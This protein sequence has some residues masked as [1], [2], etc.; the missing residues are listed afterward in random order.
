MRVVVAYATFVVTEYAVW[1]AML[2]FAFGQ[3]GATTA[4]V[5]ALAQLVPAAVAAPVAAAIAD[6]RS[7]V[8]LLVAGYLLQALGTAAAAV[9]IVVGAPPVFV[10]LAG[11]LAAS[12]VSTTRPAQAA[13]VPALARDVTELTATNVVV[14]WVESLAIMAA[15][16]LA[17]VALA[18]AGVELAFGLCAGLLVG[19]A[20]LVAPLRPKVPGGQHA[21]PA[22]RFRIASAFMEAHRSGTARVLLGLLTA[23]FLVIGALDVLFVVLA[24][25]VLALG[26]A[27]AGYLNMAYGAGGVILGASAV[28]LL[29]R[30]LGPVIV[31][32]AVLLGLALGVSAI[33]SEAVAV[34]LLLALVGG[35]RVL[36]D[37]STR[38][39]L[40]RAV[41]ADMVARLFGIAEGLSMAGLA[42]GSLLA[43]ALIALGDSR[44]ALVAV[45]SI[46]P[47]VAVICFRFLVRIDQRAQVPIVEISLLRSIPIFGGLPEPALAGIARALEP[48]EY[49]LGATII[50]EGDQG[51]CFYAIAH[52]E[53]EV[54]RGG[55]VVA[56]AG[57]GAGL[58]EMALLDGGRR[59]A[60]AVASTPVS[61]FALD[62]ESFLTAVNGHAPTRQAAEAMVRDLLERDG[63]GGD[64]QPR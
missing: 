29:G 17:G 45:G 53:V 58:G 21:I 14:G 2:V 4:G 54:R 11:V 28:M 40:Q 35:C 15:G 25:N 41:P 10:Y 9:A 50:K 19:A 44:V 61:A 46:L 51:G 33:A 62:R 59:T 7:P 55:N 16:A 39:L 34:V 8:V 18:L 13:L 3:G 24:I 49:C 20:L 42:A 57:R 32:T 43:P 22:A 36:F 12:A 52:G 37:V 23:Q 5:V 64:P 60:S 48:V 30:R 38:T 47:L 1:I 6:R 63:H 27:W 31:A 56:L 26:Q